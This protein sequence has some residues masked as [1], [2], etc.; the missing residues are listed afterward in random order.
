MRYK[1]VFY[2]DKMLIHQEELYMFI[3]YIHHFSQ[4]VISRIPFPILVLNMMLSKS[5]FPF[6]VFFHFEGDFGT[7]Y[8]L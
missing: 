1:G 5:N 3:Y 6:P 7:F 2:D 8:F 4:K